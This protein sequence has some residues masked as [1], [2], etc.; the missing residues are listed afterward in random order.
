MEP[1]LT[2]DV[3]MDDFEPTWMLA[4]M[5]CCEDLMKPTM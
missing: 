2:R 3:Q 1:T 5:G 4:P